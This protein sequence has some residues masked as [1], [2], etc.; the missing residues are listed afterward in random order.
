MTVTV[1]CLSRSGLLLGLNFFDLEFCG[2]GEAGEPG[3]LR[4]NCAEEDCVPHEHEFLLSPFS[5]P[6][7]PGQQEELPPRV[8]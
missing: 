8:G 3:V 7:I 5:F 1:R 6:T 2:S 4:S